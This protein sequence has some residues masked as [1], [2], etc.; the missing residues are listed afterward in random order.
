MPGEIL[1]LAFSEGGG[2]RVTVKSAA[3]PGRA[4]GAFRLTAEEYAELGSPPARAM[5]SDDGMAFLSA[6]EERRAA[7]ERAVRIL[8]CGDNSAMGLYRKLR[9]RG[10]P[11]SAAEAAVQEVMAR[12]YLREE[13]QAYRIAVREANGKCRGPRRILAALSEKGYPAA[14]CRRVLARAEACGDIDFAALRARLL[15][16]KLPADAPPEKKW[17]LLRQSGF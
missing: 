6:C 12:G 9:A 8:A 7:Y 1:S 13:E 11:K 14:L 3:L 2:V 4:R 15:S 16:E 5:L 17:A 10:C